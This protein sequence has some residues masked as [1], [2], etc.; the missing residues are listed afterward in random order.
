MNTLKAKV[1][2]H[3][4]VS[5]DLSQVKCFKLSPFS[6]IG[7]TNILVIEFKKRLEY[8]YN[9]FTETHEQQEINDFTEVEFP[10]WETA[11]QYTQE[12]EE[13]WQDYLDEK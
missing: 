2:N 4:G 7:K 5:V 1:I 12:L 8:I 9:P 11:R 6:S 3:A 10:D 13:I